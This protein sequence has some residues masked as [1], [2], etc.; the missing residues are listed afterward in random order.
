[1]TECIQDLEACKSA[2]ADALDCLERKKG[3]ERWR[4]PEQDAFN[5]LHAQIGDR[6]V[7]D[8]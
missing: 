5:P 8:R 2:L 4:K 3:E 7:I 6:S 1:M